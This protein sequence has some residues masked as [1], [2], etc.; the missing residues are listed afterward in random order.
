MLVYKINALASNQLISA[1]GHIFPHALVKMELVPG[2]L[3]EVLCDVLD[4]RTRTALLCVSKTIHTL[5]SPYAYFR[6]T[7]KQERL[8]EN[9]MEYV[10]IQH[11]PEDEQ[12][13]LFYTTPGSL[14]I[15]TVAFV[16]RLW[17]AKMEIHSHVAFTH[18]I[19]MM[20]TARLL[21]QYLCKTFGLESME[22]W[23]NQPPHEAQRYGHA[24]TRVVLCSL[25]R[26]IIVEEENAACLSSNSDPQM[27]PTQ[28]EVTYHYFPTYAKYE[29]MTRR[30]I[31]LE[32]TMREANQ[33]M[34]WTHIYSTQD[35]IYD[36]HGE[37]GYSTDLFLR[38]P[39][40]GILITDAYNRGI[41]SLLREILLYYPCHPKGRMRVHILTRDRRCLQHMRSW[42]LPFGQFDNPE[43][44]GFFLRDA[45]YG[46]RLQQQ[47]SKA[48]VDTFSYTYIPNWY[49][50]GGPPFREL[51]N[52]DGGPIKNIRVYKDYCVH[53]K[54]KLGMRARLLIEQ[55]DT[56]WLMT[57]YCYNLYKKLQTYKREELMGLI[58]N[59][60]VRFLSLTGNR[61]E[62]YP[63]RFVQ[64]EGL[65]TPVKAKLKKNR[66]ASPKRR[67]VRKLTTGTK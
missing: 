22:W 46:G 18:A 38:R 41:L 24:D 7:R 48:S 40:D 54:N 23:K 1:T 53:L 27:L 57:S 37:A 64:Q 61:W 29:D 56:G 17:K 2:P 60:K 31:E 9:M 62:N 30:G 58:L 4:A 16:A 32:R 25:N 39:L 3:F 47:L 13:K 34:R 28:F 67:K 21:Q 44:N 11:P 43:L 36:A 26:T 50:G 6:P 45:H 49:E 59:F 65:Y 55:L 5:A 52:A 63:E 12:R 42:E 33:S 20:R 10:Q 19:A 8:I 35:V 66:D 14:E 51:A 15:V